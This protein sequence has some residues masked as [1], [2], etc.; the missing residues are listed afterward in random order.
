MWANPIGPSLATAVPCTLSVSQHTPTHRLWWFAIPFPLP[1][2]L[3]VLHQLRTI[4][5]EVHRPQP[6]CCQQSQK[7]REQKAELVPVQCACVC[8]W[9]STGTHVFLESENNL[10]RAF[11]CCDTMWCLQWPKNWLWCKQQ[12]AENGGNRQ[13]SEAEG[14][15]QEERKTEVDIVDTLYVYLPAGV[16]WFNLLSPQLLCFS[17]SPP[18]SSLCSLS[19]HK[20]LGFL[21]EEKAGWKRTQMGGEV[22]SSLKVWQQYFMVTHFH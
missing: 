4:P 2:L 7:K 14:C 1:L 13:K 15:M 5:H 8:V 10:V 22:T 17:A 9:G 20:L 18:L 12:G 6:I 16:P 3:S 21:A 11:W 19:S